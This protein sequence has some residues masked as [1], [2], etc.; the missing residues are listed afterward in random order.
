MRPVSQRPDKKQCEELCSKIVQKSRGQHVHVDEF[1]AVL[2]GRLREDPRKK[3]NFS[4]GSCKILATSPPATTAIL[5]GNRSK[6]KPVYIDTS[7]SRYN[8]VRLAAARLG[9]E[10]AA[11][12]TGAAN[13]VWIDTSVSIDRINRLP[14]NCHINHFPGMTLLCRKVDGGRLL[15]KMKRLHPKAY[16]FVPATYLSYDDFLQRTSKARQTDQSWYIVKPD[17]GCSGKGIYLTQNPKRDSFENTVVQSYVANP[18]LIDGLKWDMRIYAL[19]LSVNP[20]KVYL[21]KDGFIRMCTE[22]YSPPDTKNAENTFVHLT[23]YAIHK[24]SKKYTNNVESV[25]GEEQGCKRSF[26]WLLDYLETKKGLKSDV[27]WGS[28]SDIVVKTL[29]SVEDHLRYCYKTAF[30]D[31]SDV[32]ASCF[33]ILGFD[34][35][36]DANLQPW[37]LEVNHAPSLTCNSSFD[38]AI[39][40]SV[41]EESLMLLGVG[42]LPGSSPTPP[43]MQSHPSATPRT[44]AMRQEN[45]RQFAIKK[46]AHESASCERFHRIYPPPCERK[47]AAYAQL[48][49]SIKERSALSQPYANAS[50]V[51]SPSSSVTLN[52]LRRCGGYSS[53]RRP[54]TAADIRRSRGLPAPT[55]TARV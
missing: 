10:E 55:K 44:K 6:R 53:L 50:S 32:G 18:L 52:I 11:P 40:S 37:I 29:L 14:P 19:V 39:K 31:S 23:N 30:P 12:E 33:E 42:D 2:T 16:H 20:L 49:A 15:N 54:T 41:V 46:D 9:W 3:Q 51:S 4:R 24:K 21:Y 47:A 25:D 13:I 34:V 35:L 7:G 5:R 43:R 36:V 45:A 22:K 48:V 28:I 17:S 8:V 38:F 26:A 1:Y 27:F